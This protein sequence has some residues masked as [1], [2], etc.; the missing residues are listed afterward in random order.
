MRGEK[1]NCIA[2]QFTV[3]QLRSVGWQEL[4]HNTLHCI[5]A[6]R[7]AVGRIMSQYSSL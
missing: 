6:E 2:I 3:L 1:K 4:Y 5:V 7:L